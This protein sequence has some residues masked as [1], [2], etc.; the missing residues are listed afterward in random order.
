MD[1]L[2][3]LLR[4]DGKNALITGASRG[5]GLAIAQ[6]YR[7]AGASVFIT[8]RDAANLAQ[9]QQL[10]ERVEGA[11]QVIAH[12]AS[13]A[14][15]AGIEGTIAHHNETLGA[16]DILVNNAGRNSPV[17]P[18][19]ES[20]LAEW[21]K[22]YAVN[23]EAPLRLIRCALDSSMRERGGV[24]INITTLGVHMPTPKLGA[25]S[26]SK[27]AMR[28]MGYQLAGEL[29]PKVRVIN[30]A[31]GIVK[32]EMARGLWQDREEQMAHTTL[33]HRIGMP[34]DIAHAALFAASQMASWMTG[35]DLIVDGGSSMKMLDPELDALSPT[36]GRE[37]MLQRMG[38]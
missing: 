26:G 30:I 23:V 36:A 14:D 29:A 17:A 5:I 18:L 6:I 7:E 12:A 31:P 28:H 2:E 21:R 22:T 37:D 16:I 4:L 15:E 27:T 25:Y 24:I 10:L 8:A 20:D 19:I 9:A 33:C 34:V 35:V 11:G 3:A 32:T 38:V 1:D 13:V